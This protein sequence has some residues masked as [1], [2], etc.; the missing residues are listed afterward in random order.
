MQ[1]NSP[2]VRAAAC[3]VLVVVAEGCC[4]AC[5]SHLAEVLQV[6]AVTVLIYSSSNSGSLES[7]DS[8]ALKAGCGACTSHS[9]EALQGPAVTVSIN[10]TVKVL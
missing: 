5:T 10:M 2:D 1:S 8:R 6:R 3:T 9:A 4:D 7:A